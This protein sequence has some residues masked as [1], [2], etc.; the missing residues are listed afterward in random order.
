MG[1]VRWIDGHRELVPTRKFD[2]LPD[3]YV[4]T[5]PSNPDFLQVSER[6]PG[7][8][9]GRILRYR[10]WAP[11]NQWVD[12]EFIYADREHKIL[13]LDYDTGKFFRTTFKGEKKNPVAL[14]PFINEIQTGD[15]VASQSQS[16]KRVSTGR[17][18]TG[19]AMPGIHWL[20]G[21]FEILSEIDAW[22][23]Q[24]VRGPPAGGIAP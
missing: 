6:L 18:V 16:L 2:E 21:R 1:K 3:L 22:S 4:V 15:L 9:F 14:F 24:K 20:P 12:L 5:D 7:G 17:L 11:G 23:R 19:R 13:I 8:G 10:G